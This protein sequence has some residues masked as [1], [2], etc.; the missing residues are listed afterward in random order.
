MRNLD[1]STSFYTAD[2]EYI[3][4]YEYDGLQMHAFDPAKC[5]K[6]QK[7]TR[8]KRKNGHQPEIQLWCESQ[9]R[10]RQMCC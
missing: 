3:Y 5:P 2:G 7:Q 4:S 9:W 6:D 10:T 8:I 1:L